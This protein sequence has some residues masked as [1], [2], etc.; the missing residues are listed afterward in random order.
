MYHSYVKP[1]QKTCNGS[2]T[3]SF[4]RISQVP[5]ILRAQRADLKSL[6]RTK[7]DGNQLKPIP[8]LS[9]KRSSGYFL[10]R[11]WTPPSDG[12]DF[13][14]EDIDI[15]QNPLLYFL[16]HQDDSFHES[17]CDPHTEQSLEDIM[18]R[19]KPIKRRCQSRLPIL[20]KRINVKPPL[21]PKPPTEGQ[22]KKTGAR[23]W[24]LPP[25]VKSATRAGKEMES[26]NSLRTVNDKRA[27][28]LDIEKLENSEQK[29]IRPSRLPVLYERIPGYVPLPPKPRK[30]PMTR[31]TARIRKILPPLHP[32]VRGRDETN[33][34]DCSLQPAYETKVKE[35]PVCSKI[36]S[37]LHP[38]L[39]IFAKEAPVLPPLVPSPPT[40]CPTIK[41]GARQRRIIPLVKLDIYTGE[42]IKNHY[43]LR[44]V[45]DER[46]E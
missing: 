38:G 18:E 32:P 20:A 39:P 11:C 16:L 43:S 31:T 28:Q 5:G 13:N 19:L 25:I 2:D 41:R 3:L 37:F 22:S 29:P 9:P 30:L 35:K 21:M 45:N 7:Q 8:S 33:E 36:E 14:V 10:G 24:R 1:T 40:N 12:S 44:T 23:P 27:Q 17:Y 6:G 4:P 26:H 34:N 46:D 15:N 42:E